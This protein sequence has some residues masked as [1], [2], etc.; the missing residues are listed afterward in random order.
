[1]SWPIGLTRMAAGS[2]LL[3]SIVVG[4]PTRTTPAGADYTPVDAQA[5][6]AALQRSTAQVMAF[7][8]NLERHDGTAVA[9]AGG[10]LLTN[11]H[12]VEGSRL[13]DVVPD[14]AATQVGGQPLV[15]DAGDVAVVTGAGQA[16][17]AL[18]LAAQDPA[19][20]TTVRVAGFPAG[21]PG[22]MMMT[23][24]VTDYVAGG[25]VGEPWPVIHL[26]SGVRPGMSGGPV[27]D[28]A[29]H[30]AGILFGNELPDNRALAVP[31][32]QLRHLL[33]GHDFVPTSC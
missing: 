10:Q 28:P 26:S 2:A 21:A 5:A 32:S 9:V 17:P 25:A 15:A 29:G 22:L 31:A 3:L 20:G 33:A 12:V 4:T 1:M 16:P 30:L 11:A 7:G 18:T 13:I 23:M 27:L 14:N 8:C 24:Q 19:P 6:L